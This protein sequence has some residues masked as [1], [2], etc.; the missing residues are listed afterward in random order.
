MNMFID[1]NKFLV[2]EK[3]QFFVFL[4]ILHVFSHSKNRLKI[5]YQILKVFNLILKKIVSFKV[6]LK[7]FFRFLI[8]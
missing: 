2:Y 7:S 5:F 6:R 1:N 4:F 3:S 8:K